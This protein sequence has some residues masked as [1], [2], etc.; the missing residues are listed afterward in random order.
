MLIFKSLSPSTI[1]AQGEIES[2]PVFPREC[3]KLQRLLGSGAFG[4][5]Y[6]GV[7]VGSQIIGV[8]PE[9]RVAVKVHLIGLNCLNVSH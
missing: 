1:P 5:V 3:L 9:R 7:T 8:V 2:L 4:E 6:E